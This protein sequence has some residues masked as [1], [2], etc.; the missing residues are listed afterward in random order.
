MP[1]SVLGQAE[2][3]LTVLA[4]KLR[5]EWFWTDRWNT[6]SAFALPMEARGLYREMLTQ[7][8]VRDAKLPND[9]E[10][11]R[12]ITGCTEAEWERNWPKVKRFWRENGTTIFNETQV[13]VYTETLGI[14]ERALARAKAGAQ[15]SAQAR[16]EQ[17]LKQSP[18]SPSPSKTKTKSQSQAPDQITTT[19]TDNGT[20]LVSLAPTPPKEA[21]PVRWNDLACGLFIRRYGGTAPGGRITKALRPLVTKHGEEVV[22]RAWESY[23]EETEAE[24]VSSER[25]S[26]TFGRWEK[27]M[28]RKKTT[29]DRTR[30]ALTSWLEKKGEAHD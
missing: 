16:L 18:P 12:R 30:D 11:I 5:A 20:A 6:S 27:G 26:A 25:F 4:D 29:T 3:E 28:G 15:A 17:K 21:V 14:K 23:L 7:A 1:H 8:W 22:L 19:E 10:A 2:K 13:E 9:Y 24:Y